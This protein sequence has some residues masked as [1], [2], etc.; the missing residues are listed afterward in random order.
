M[1]ILSLRFFICKKDNALASLQKSSKDKIIF[2]KT[3]LYIEKSY[4][5]FPLICQFLF[6][7]GLVDIAELSF[8]FPSIY[9]VPNVLTEP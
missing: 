1:K 5:C 2:V 6:K 7:I 3:I 9:S 8:L 4:Y